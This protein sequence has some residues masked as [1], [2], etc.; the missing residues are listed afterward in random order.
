MAKK[1]EEN[2][3]NWLKRKG[4]AVKYEHAG[5]YCIKIDRHIVYIGKSFNMLK[6]ISQHYVGI[7]VARKLKYSLLANAQRMG[8]SINFDVLYY[9]TQTHPSAL[10]QEI[11]EKEGELIRQYRPALNTQI[12][13]AE[14][15]TKYEYHKI[16]ENKI[17]EILC[18]INRAGGA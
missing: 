10:E 16:D 12:P 6:R 13:K 2:V 3:Y 15:W 5:I 1:Y 4:L 14:D 17:I 7:K 18:D 11:G 8:H 9:A